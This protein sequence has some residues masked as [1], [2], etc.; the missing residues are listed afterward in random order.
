M[1]CDRVEKKLKISSTLRREKNFYSDSFIH[2]M[3]IDKRDVFPF[4]AAA[5]IPANLLLTPFR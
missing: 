1:T 2:A 4:N 3:S 5:I